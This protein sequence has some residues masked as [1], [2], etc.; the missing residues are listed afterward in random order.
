MM[1]VTLIMSIISLLLCTLPFSR[2]FLIIIV[3]IGQFRLSH[4]FRWKRDFMYVSEVNSTDATCFQDCNDEWKSVFEHEF[5]LSTTDFY[6]FPLHPAVLDRAGFVTYCNISEQ[7]TQCYI[8]E[9][10]DQSAVRVFS[11]SNFLCRF[12]K[13][14]FLEARSCLEKT[15]PLTFLKCDQTCHLEALKNIENR[16]RAFPGKVFTKK[17]TSKYER[18]LGLLCSFQSCYLQCEELIVKGSCE[19]KEAD[20][21]LALI[22]QYVTWHASDIYDWHILS[23]SLDHFPSSCQRL[24]LTLSNSDPVVRIISGFS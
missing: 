8:N 13:H 24:A 1:N 20:S 17:E 7:R 22:S 16:E 9:C 12:K 23:D 18:E 2:F 21:A 10:N 3:I 11:P 19:R 6:D 4:Q 14:H 15:E 5:N